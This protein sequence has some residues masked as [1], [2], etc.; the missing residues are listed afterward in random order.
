M[1]VMCPILWEMKQLPFSAI[2]SNMRP[3]YTLADNLRL[4]TLLWYC[5]CIRSI[6]F[7]FVCCL[8]RICRTWCLPTR[9]EPY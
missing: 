5:I 1:Y 3:Q 9:R 7:S 4:S 6:H 2:L 8:F